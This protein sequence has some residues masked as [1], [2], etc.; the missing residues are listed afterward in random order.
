[1]LFQTGNIAK[2]DGPVTF[3]LYGLELLFFL[4]DLDL[5]LISDFK[6]SFVKYCPFFPKNHKFFFLAGCFYRSVY[7]LK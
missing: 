1:M 5:Q 2:I 6:S 3:L 4:I 7:F